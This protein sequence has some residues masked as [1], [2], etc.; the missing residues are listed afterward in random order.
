MRTM[1]MAEHFR[2]GSALLEFLAGRLGAPDCW[3][4]DCKV[5]ATVTPS[6]ELNM[7]HPLKRRRRGRSTHTSRG[8]K[9]P[10]RD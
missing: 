2:T 7:L 4:N 1:N 9:C 8:R 3:P 5:Q 6:P 10:A